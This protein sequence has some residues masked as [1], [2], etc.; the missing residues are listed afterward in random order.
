MAKFEQHRELVDD[1]YKRYMS[2]TFNSFYCDL[3]N[4]QNKTNAVILASFG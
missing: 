3:I 4:I 2:I 1:I